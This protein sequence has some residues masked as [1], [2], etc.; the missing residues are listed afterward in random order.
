MNKLAEKYI[1]DLNISGVK[2]KEI[3]ETSDYYCFSYFHPTE[4]YVGQGQIFINKI[5]NRFFVYGS[6]NTNPKKD[7][8]EK[9]T[10]E[11]EVRKIFSNFDIRKNY[12][13]K[14]NRIFRKLNLIE[15]L[16]ELSLSYTIP[17]IVGSDIFR[18]PK[19]YSRKILE[20]RLNELPTKF[21]NVKAIKVVEILSLNEKSKTVEFEIAKHIDSVKVNRV[22]RATDSDLQP[23]W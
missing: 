2:L 11:K 5:D 22:E 6:G 8:I 10:T 17:E 12:D 18:I 7:F 23:I 13:V 19:P 9:I 14:I 15:K 16:L 4:I 20:E 1:E 3:E 21:T